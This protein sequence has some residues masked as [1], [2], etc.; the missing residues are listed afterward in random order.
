MREYRARQVEEV[1][2]LDGEAL[3]AKIEEYRRQ[4]LNKNDLFM[5][6]VYRLAMEGKNAKYAE[7]WWR[8]SRPDPEEVK[9]FEITHADR[10]RMAKE[11]FQTMR[12]ERELYGGRCPVCGTCTDNDVLP[13]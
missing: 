9:P 3:D 7:L 10:I 8:M 1:A 4:G 13:Q 11:I 12:E 6:T 2:S 5:D